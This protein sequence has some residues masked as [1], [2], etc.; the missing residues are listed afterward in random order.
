M[1]CEIL[2]FSR[3]LIFNRPEGVVGDPN[4]GG[5]PFQFRICEALVAEGCP[6]YHHGVRAFR[7]GD[8][9]VHKPGFEHSG[10]EGSHILGIRTGACDHNGCP[11]FG[12]RLPQQRSGGPG[13]K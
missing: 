4:D 1:R 2:Y 12:S 8:H 7:Q 6:L 3:N 5:V 11:G 13:I 10:Q 9:I